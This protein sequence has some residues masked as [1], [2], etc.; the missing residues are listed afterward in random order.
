M[1]GMR[2]QPLMRVGAAFGV[3]RQPG[4]QM[5]LRAVQR[6]HRALLR[7]RSR[8]ARAVALDGVNGLRNRLRRGQITQPPAGHRIRLRKAV[9]DDGVLVMRRGKARHAHVFRAVIDELLVN[10]VA[11]DEHALLDADVAERLDFL[12]R[13]QRTGRVAGRVQQ[14]Q[15]RPRRDGLA[16]LLRA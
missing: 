6:R 9:H 11:H 12:A 8:V 7:E 5:V 16:K 4:L 14:E 15:P 10:L 2:V 1:P 13:V 3:F